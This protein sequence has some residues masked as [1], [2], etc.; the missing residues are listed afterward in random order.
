[1]SPNLDVLGRLIDEDT[2]NLELSIERYLSH[3]A[4]E[5]PMSVMVNVFQSQISFTNMDI[6]ILNLQLF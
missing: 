6:D 1:M 4:R 2:L 3:E 5:I